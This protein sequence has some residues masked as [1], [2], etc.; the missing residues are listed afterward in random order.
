MLK[1][2]ELVLESLLLEIDKICKNDLCMKLEKRVD[3]PFL[4]KDYQSK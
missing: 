3:K 2:I 1:Q 4:F